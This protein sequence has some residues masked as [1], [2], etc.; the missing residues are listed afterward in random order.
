V[1][2]R[3]TAREPC[4]TIY[5]VPEERGLGVLPEP[6]YIVHEDL[7][8]SPG[9]RFRG[10]VLIPFPLHQRLQLPLLALDAMASPSKRKV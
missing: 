10:G 4:S 3:L 9:P 2:T 8:A 5:G 6:I 1:P 7:Q